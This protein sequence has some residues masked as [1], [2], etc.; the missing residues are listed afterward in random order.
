MTMITGYEKILALIDKKNE[1][2]VSEVSPRINN[3]IN[4][5]NSETTLKPQGFRA[6]GLSVSGEHPVSPSL[7][8]EGPD[9][10]EEIIELA[11][12][13]QLTEAVIVPVLPAYQN[14]L[15]PRVWFCLDLTTAEV[16]TPD[17]AFTSEELIVIIPLLIENRELAA[18]LVS[19]KRIFGGT[20][21]ASSLSDLSPIEPHDCQAGAEDKPHP[22]VH[23]PLDQD[24][25][26]HQDSGGTPSP[27]KGVP[28]P[29][30]HLVI[31]RSVKGYLHNFPEYTGPRTRIEME[32]MEGPDVGKIL[33]DNVSLLHPKESRG[34]LL[35]RLRIAKRLGLITRGPMGEIIQQGG[36][37]LL[38]GVVC[39]V[40]VAYK[41]LGGRKIPMV[42]NYELQ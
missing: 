23:A 26:H 3:G 24:T 27:R 9:W 35:R 20:I 14:I 41:T 5:I 33:V 39:W 42:D 31:I 13:G 21:I 40:D 4:L 29:G 32:I 17:L 22:G 34:M 37:K 12:A 11:L 38:K 30:R 18:T 15:G 2:V 16:K 7:P 6:A 1:K 36:W 25:Y 28:S 19:A 10:I 8:D